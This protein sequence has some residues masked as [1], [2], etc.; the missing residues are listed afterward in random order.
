VNL[1]PKERER[2][3][4]VALR[5]HRE[6]PNFGGRAAA[7]KSVESRAR[8]ASEV[9]QHL[10]TAHAERI[11]SAFL[12]GLRSKNINTRVK[13]A[14]GLLKLALASERLDVTEHKGELEHLDRQ[15]LID[16]LTHGFTRGPAAPLLRRAL[17]EKNAVVDGTASEI[18]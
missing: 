4:Q 10:V 11:E 15:Q 5:L 18:D 17:A 9:A 6:H 16:K 1:S 13:S 12:A 2:R 8:R 14:E 3:R 7:R